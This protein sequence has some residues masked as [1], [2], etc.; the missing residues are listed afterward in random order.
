MPWEDLSSEIAETFAGLQAWDPDS[1][2]AFLFRRTI[3]K[4]E[5][6]EAAQ[7]LRLAKRLQA[8]ERSQ[9]ESASRALERRLAPLALGPT[10]AARR[11]VN[12]AHGPGAWEER[13]KLAL[14]RARYEK[15][16]SK[17]PRQRKKSLQAR[18]G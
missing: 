7:F 18:T 11:H 4:D 15:E 12:A 5:N 6:P 16:K 13:Q 9:A 17:P 2:D 3:L 14:S 10:A 8:L 1:G